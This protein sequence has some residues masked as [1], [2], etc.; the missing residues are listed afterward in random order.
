MNELSGK[1]KIHHGSES[2][3]KEE[4]D[5]KGNFLSVDSLSLSASSL[6]TPTET[7]ARNHSR[8]DM[9]LENQT[10][11]PKVEPINPA[12]GG[13]R[14]SLSWTQG[15][16]NL[17]HMAESKRK[18]EILPKEEKA[19][20]PIDLIQFPS[21]RGSAN[22]SP[23]VNDFDSTLSD[24]NVTESECPHEA[25]NGTCTY[26][27][28]CIHRHVKNENRK[29]TVLGK[30]I[31]KPKHLAD[32]THDREKQSV[33]SG[34]RFNSTNDDFLPSGAPDKHKTNQTALEIATLESFRT[35]IDEQE[36]RK[37]LLS[38]TRRDQ[39][40]TS[41]DLNKTTRELS[42][43]QSRLDKHQSVMDR[44]L[45][46]K[47][48]AQTAMENVPVITEVQRRN[49][50]N[51]GEHIKKVEGQS[52]ALERIQDQ[53]TKMGELMQVFMEQSV[54][55]SQQ[56]DL[57]SFSSIR[58]QWTPERRTPVDGQSPNPIGGRKPKSIKIS[59]ILT[60]LR[61]ERDMLHDM[62]CSSAKENSLATKQHLITLQ[63][64][65][66]GCVGCQICR[67]AADTNNSRSVKHHWK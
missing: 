59:T 52:F 18:T 30:A 31:V 56:Y 28:A 10:L 43:L 1:A 61:D 6:P 46:D 65:Q 12:A 5:K 63:K 58:E 66:V 57:Q 13:R 24:I 60:L 47:H 51:L 8:R 64:H 54:Q 32:V 39:E 23:D 11:Q 36:K 40:K 17:E 4:E 53:V 16:D 34:K 48:I 27:A 22:T 25:T 42:Y 45:N 20:P 67:E 7:T 37:Q 33:S 2:R 29:E 14:V 41:E 26:G 21:L 50:T 35:Q 44:I 55:R 9:E 3:N 49:L 38:V 15:V 19:E 62:S